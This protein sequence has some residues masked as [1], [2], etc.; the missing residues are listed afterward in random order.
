MNKEIKIGLSVILALFVVFVG[1]LVYKLRGPAEEPSLANDAESAAENEQQERPILASGPGSLTVLAANEKPERTPRGDSHSAD[2]GPRLS[3][4][5]YAHRNG[6]ATAGASD[7]AGDQPRP[8]FLPQEPT[9]AVATGDDRY[10]RKDRYPR[11]HLA[12][13]ENVPVAPPGHVAAAGN[14]QASEV[15]AGSPSGGGRDTD[16]P[17]AIVDPFSHRSTGGREAEQ[18]ANRAGLSPADDVQLTPSP[19]PS[20]HDRAAGDRAARDTKAGRGG[21]GEISPT[22]GSGDTPPEQ[23]GRA[24]GADAFVPRSTDTPAADIY[25]ESRR[26]SGEAY[27][28]AAQG[29]AGSRQPADEPPDARMPYRDRM[30]ETFERTQIRGGTAAPNASGMERPLRQAETYTVEPNDSYWTISEKVYGTGGY[31]KAIQRHNQP[32]TGRT[33]GLNVGQT[34]SLPT[35]EVL[36]QKYPELC[37]K[38][39]GRRTDR[40]QMMTAAAGARDQLAGGG[41][42]YVV[43]K[44]DT[45][46]DIAKYELGKPSRWNEIYE[47][48]R[49]QLGQDF[50]H[51]SPGMKLLLPDGGQSETITSKPQNPY[52]R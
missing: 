52:R 51:L 20:E 38:P 50:D 15:A 49:D 33:E 47:L 23:F 36:A 11:E 43:E 45:L 27:D 19:G 31:F 7:A 34:L 10:P 37:P 44:G 39:R 35:V 12:S 13:D 46:F 8:S 22:A 9:D 25:G 4:D 48:N 5:R 17:N 14:Q 21:A 29:S 28:R 30:A 24:R 16:G 32:K 42:V 18:A 40:G 26:R 2:G 6:P 3:A 41:R 1:V